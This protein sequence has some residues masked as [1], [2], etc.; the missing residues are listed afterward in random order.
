MEPSGELANRIGKELKNKS[1]GTPLAV[2]IK[3]LSETSGGV[4]SNYWK[5]KILL[6]KKNW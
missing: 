3:E 1:R 2:I 5:K 4:R 6:G